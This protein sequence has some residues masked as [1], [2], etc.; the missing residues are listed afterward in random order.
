VHGLYK[1]ALK[2]E[3]L[4][5]E[6]QQAFMQEVVMLRHDCVHR[7]GFT[8]DGDKLDVF[9]FDF[10]CKVANAPWGSVLQVYRPLIM[11][12]YD[13]WASGELLEHLERIPD[14]RP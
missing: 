9:T 6:V 14:Y 11:R 5:D 1:N 10:L 2:V 4:P 12:G 13:A 3:F 8:R 7:N